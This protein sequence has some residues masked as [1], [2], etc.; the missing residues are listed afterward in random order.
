M[1]V[2]HC[3][4]S[5]SQNI[6]QATPIVLGGVSQINFSPLSAKIQ[7]LALVVTGIYTDRADPIVGFNLK[8]FRTNKMKRNQF[9][10]F[11]SCV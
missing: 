5:S 8:L 10:L 4:I 11:F 2:A 7:G 3:F 1:V 9:S 6:L